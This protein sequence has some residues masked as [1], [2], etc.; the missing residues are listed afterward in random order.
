MG[1]Q[2]S[3]YRKTLSIQNTN[4]SINVAN[5]GAQFLSLLILAYF[6]AGMCQRAQPVKARHSVSGV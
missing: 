2:P 4:N 6:A 5:Q 1:I 3:K